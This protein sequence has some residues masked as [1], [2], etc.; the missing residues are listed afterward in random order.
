MSA[1]RITIGRTFSQTPVE[2]EDSSN[3]VQTF[4]LYT[5]KRADFRFERV[6]AKEIEEKTFVDTDTNGRDQAGLTPESLK[7]IIRTIRLQQFFPAIGIRRGEQVEILDGSR[8]RAAALHCK[9]GLN[10]LVTDADISAE[11]ARKLA[12]DIQTAREHSLREIGMRLLALKAGGLSQKE[13]AQSQGLSPAK[14]T[15]ALQAASVPGELLA[16][17][18]NHA[19]LTH[20]DYKALLIACEQLQ[21]SGQTLDTLIDGLA[22][23]VDDVRASENLADDEI[24][25]AILR[26][27]RAESAAL[28]KR[29]VKEKAVTTSLWSFADKDRYARKKSRGRSFSYE[30]NRQSIELQDELDRVIA[31]TLKKHLAD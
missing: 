22:G 1:K 25:N 28:L 10:I 5:G 18:P 24:K 4:V 19:E 13:I 2:T 7:D 29:S 27:V 16:L 8:R 23:K 21:E 14:V 12:Q 3:P 9:T 15:R 31:A 17:F 11:E 30:F 6:A 20:P 26:Y